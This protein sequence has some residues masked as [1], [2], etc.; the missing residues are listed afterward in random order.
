MSFKSDIE[1]AQEARLS[2]INEIA[3]ELSIDDDFLE[4]YGKYMAK[5]DYNI[6]DKYAD[7]ANGKLILVTAINPTSAGEGKTTTTVGLGDALR[8]SGRR[9]SSH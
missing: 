2:N 5:V 6:L 1:I 4:V 9:R 7:R 3:K 8:K